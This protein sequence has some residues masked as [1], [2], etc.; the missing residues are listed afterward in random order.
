MYIK[1]GDYVFIYGA[2]GVIRGAGRVSSRSG[3]GPYSVRFNHRYVRVP[4]ERLSVHP[5]NRLW[6]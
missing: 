4:A 6:N 2:N 1:P 3:S 5:L